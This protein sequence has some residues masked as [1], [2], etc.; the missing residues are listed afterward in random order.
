MRPDSRHRHGQRLGGRSLRRPHRP[1]AISRTASPSSFRPSHLFSASADHRQRHP[2]HHPG[3]IA[4]RRIG[5]Q[6]SRRR[7]RLPCACQAPGL[8]AAGSRAMSSS[9]CNSAAR[10]KPSRCPSIC[11][12]A[13][14]R[15]MRCHSTSQP[16]QPRS[17]HGRHHAD[18]AA[19]QSQP[20]A[21]LRFPFSVN[22]SGKLAVIPDLSRPRLTHDRPGVFLRHVDERLQARGPGEAR[23]RAQ[24]D[25]ARSDQRGAVRSGH[26]SGGHSGGRR[27]GLG[28]S[29][30]DARRRTKR[31][32]RSTRSRDTARRRPT[33]ACTT[34]SRYQ[35]PFED[36]HRRR[37]GSTS[38]TRRSAAQS[39]SP[40]ATI[41][42]ISR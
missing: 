22:E 21:L 6:P 11:P 28:R 32:R 7:P 19:S 35:S 17:R 41:S 33:R 14:T 20:P 12:D 5:E 18:S 3:R 10:A 36:G 29:A 16:V 8:V 25:W 39:G 15:S 42:S 4:R 1:G 24:A 13:L 27:P 23:S 9:R 31:S 40:P 30:P 38:T 2:R 34:A 37:R 26:L